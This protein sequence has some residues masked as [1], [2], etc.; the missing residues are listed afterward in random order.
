[1]NLQK[2]QK[3]S[4]ENLKNIPESTG[5]YFFYNSEHTIIYIGK[6]INLRRRVAS[7]FKKLGEDIHIRTKRMVHNIAAFNI[8]NVETELEALLLEDRFI[9]KYLPEYNIKQKNYAEYKYLYFTNDQFPAIRITDSSDIPNQHAVFGPFPDG[10]YIDNLKE[11]FSKHLKF[12]KCT[13]S[14]PRDKC[15]NYEISKCSGPCR[16]KIATHDY[17]KIAQRV[18]DFLKGDFNYFE[19]I[20]KNQMNYYSSERNFEE[21]SKTRDLLKYLK[22]LCNR[23]EFIHKFGNTKTII[24]ENGKDEY[25]YIFNW[26]RLVKVT[27]KSITP[28]QINNF[29]QNL[30]DGRGPDDERFALDRANIVWKWIKKKKRVAEISITFV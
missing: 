27:K 6:S 23:Q 29:L 18:R 22:N 28:K 26:G 12:R 25:T 8:Q 2:R 20:L 3:I 17:K 13:D 11:I 1:M 30:E 4:R 5:I 7:Y 19:K 16:R 15:M 10:Y 14:F 24:S 21:A 9:K